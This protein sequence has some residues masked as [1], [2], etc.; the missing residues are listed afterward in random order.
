M[1]ADNLYIGTHNFH[2]ELL[3]KENCDIMIFD[4]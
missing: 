2:R 3:K 4:I 1:A